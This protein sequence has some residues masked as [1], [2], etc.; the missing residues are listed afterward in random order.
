M[1]IRPLL[2]ERSHIAAD[3]ANVEKGMIDLQMLVARR[4]ITRDRSELTLAH[5][6]E[7]LKRLTRQL[8]DLDRS[9]SLLLGG[10]L[11]YC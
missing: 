6:R 5:C 4:A 7:E 2:V 10:A 9:L 1:E 3:L 8:A 11:H